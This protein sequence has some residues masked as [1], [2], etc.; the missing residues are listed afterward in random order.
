MK[1]GLI[2]PLLLS[3]FAFAA[4]ANIVVT[5]WK[6]IFKGVDRAVGTNLPAP[7]T[8]F[9]NNG[10]VHTNSRLQVVNCV[11]VDLTDPDVQFFTTPRASNYVAESRETTSL[12]VSNFLQ[13]YGLQ[14]A[15]TANFY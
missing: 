14:V 12:T 15:C 4:S 11:R 5:P 6:P 2:L 9:T 10:V 3:V 1:R 7:A 13:S 8:L